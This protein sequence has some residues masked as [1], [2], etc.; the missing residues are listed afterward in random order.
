[1][2][3]DVDMLPRPAPRV[4]LPCKLADLPPLPPSARGPR[5]LAA[6][7]PLAEVSLTALFRETSEG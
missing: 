6:R 7:L 4:S 1:M 3:G 2:L 5:R